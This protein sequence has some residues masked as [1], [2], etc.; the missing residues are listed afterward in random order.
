MN[1]NRMSF[2]NSLLPI[3]LSVPPKTWK[4]LVPFSLGLILFAWLLNTPPGLLG[5]A[6][7][8]G[9]A[10]CHRIDLRSFHL[11]S[12][13]ISLCARCTGMYLGAVSGILFQWAFGRK[14][15]K[16]PPKK[17]LVILGIFVAAFGIDGVNSTFKL[18][19][20]SSLLYAPHNTL[21]LITGTGMGLV[22]AAT[23]LPAF[24]QTIWQRIN[25]NPAIVSLRQ[26]SGLVGLAFMLIFLVLTENPL[27][28]Y[29]L[30]LISAAGVLIILTM[31]YAMLWIIVTKTENS[32]EKPAQLWLPISAGFTLAIIQIVFLDLGRFWLT[33]TWEGFHLFLG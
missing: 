21:R 30:S 20:G 27:V 6:D 28:L 33:D 4:G 11:G 14:G 10:V 25:P 15:T 2:L 24:H 32:Y 22:I 17:I 8:V 26:F 7:A 5:K 1:G 19:F 31:V 3:K 29:P 18:F 16:L 23:V 12:R 13:P 9:Y